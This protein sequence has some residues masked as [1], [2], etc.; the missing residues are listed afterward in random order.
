MANNK[1]GVYKIDGTE[2]EVSFNFWTDISAKDK[3]RFVN[4]VTDTIVDDN[5]YYYFLRDLIFDFEIIEVFTDV[6]TSDIGESSDA[7]SKIEE[8]ISTTNIVD[9]VKENV[10]DGLI[11][12]LSQAVDE[13]IEYRT[14]VHRNPISKSVAG[15][16]KTI[17]DKFNEIDIEG[18]AQLTKMLNGMNGEIT[19]D[20]VIEAYANS[21][22]FLKTLEDR[23]KAHDERFEKIAN[24]ISIS[25][26]N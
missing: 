23:Q 7:I 18:M 1:M 10:E 26:I 13:N 3:M 2:R 22:I 21:P 11:E 8:L 20:K 25:E 16:I 9:I 24:T 15:L 14:G 5:Y 6:D 17:E 12:E 4:A 19:A